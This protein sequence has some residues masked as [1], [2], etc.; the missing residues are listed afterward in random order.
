MHQMLTQLKLARIREIHQEWF[1]RAAETQMPYPDFLRGL[2]QEELLAREE[3]QLRRRLKD[4]SFPFE[5]TLDD[6]DFRLRPELNR[7]V[8]LRYLDERFITQGRAL[9]LVGPTGLGKT[10]LSVAVGLALLMRYAS[11]GKY[12]NG[13]AAVELAQ[14]AEA[15]GFDS[16]WTVEHVVVPAQYQSKYPYS[17]S[18]KMGSGLEDFPIPDPLIWLAYIASATRTI[19]LGTAILI[20]PQ[21]NPVV[22]A[23]A[24]ATL[25]HL[26]GGGRVHRAVQ[27]L[28]RLRG[29]GARAATRRP[30]QRHRCPHG[31]VDG[32]ATRGGVPWETAPRYLLRDRDAVY[33]VMFSNRAQ[34]GDRRSQDGA[35]VPLA[36]SVRGGSYRHPPPRVSR[37]RRGAERNP[38]APPVERVPPLLPRG[39]N[40]PLPGEGRPGA[41]TGGAP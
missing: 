31:S 15:A 29:P 12:S 22:T 20:L 37:P 16:I 39:S 28:V 34:T 11:L 21:R 18:G 25:D 24:V 27:G 8:F 5:K 14:A 32:P 36:E 23:K 7:Q 9:V 10:H 17:P 4:A 13:P 26:A 1:D 41:T 2:L 3:N 6:F 38:S 33:G 30:H 19:K 40:T 35:P